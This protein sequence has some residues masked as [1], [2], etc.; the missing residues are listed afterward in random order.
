MGDKTPN[1]FSEGIAW[2][3]GQMADT[4]SSLILQNKKVA[5]KVRGK[6]GCQRSKAREVGSGLGL[7]LNGVMR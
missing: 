5:T 3:S 4:E 2:L 1:V 6:H 7:Q